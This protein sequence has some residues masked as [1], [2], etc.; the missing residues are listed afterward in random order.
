MSGILDDATYSI[1]NTPLVRVRKLIRSDC[2]VP[3]KLEGHNP[4]S[5][6]KDRIGLAMIEAGERYLSTVLFN[7]ADDPRTP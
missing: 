7:F 6:V 5:S 1:G 4:M 3:A 2:T